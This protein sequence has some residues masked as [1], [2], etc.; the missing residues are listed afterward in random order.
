MDWFPGS[1]PPWKEER[2]KNQPE[3]FATVSAFFWAGGL[4]SA[5]KGEEF[6]KKFLFFPPKSANFSLLYERKVLDFE[7]RN[8]KFSKYE[9]EGKTAFQMGDRD[10]P[11]NRMTESKRNR[12]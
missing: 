1:K 10:S 4:S 8:L 12:H 9:R 2:N 11:G 3:T 7:G 6:L 5:M